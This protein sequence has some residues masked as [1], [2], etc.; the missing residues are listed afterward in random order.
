AEIT[1]EV[2]ELQPAIR[3]S[4]VLER[5]RTVSQRMPPFA[6][7]AMLLP[8]LLRGYTVEV[9]QRE[10]Q[11]GVSQRVIW[12]DVERPTQAIYGRLHFAAAQERIRQVVVGLRA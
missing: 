6:E 2:A 12:P 4:V 7:G 11:V 8:Q 3:I 9:M 10:Q 1:R 5:G